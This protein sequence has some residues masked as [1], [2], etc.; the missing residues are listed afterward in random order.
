MTNILDNINTDGTLND[1]TVDAIAHEAYAKASKAHDAAK[2]AYGDDWQG[3][4]KQ[5]AALSAAMGKAI[6][7]HVAAYTADIRQMITLYA[8]G[9]QLTQLVASAKN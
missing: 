5:K 2:A 6:K 4:P 7:E 1:A 3:S 9:K 8:M